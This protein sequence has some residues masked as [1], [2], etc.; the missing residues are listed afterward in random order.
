MYTASEV[1]SSSTQ[2]FARLDLPFCTI[3]SDVVSDGTRDFELMRIWIGIFGLLELEDVTRAKF[4]VLL[5]T[6][7]ACDRNKRGAAGVW[8]MQYVDVKRFEQTTSQM[9]IEFSECC[10]ECV[11]HV[12]IEIVFA[13]TRCLRRGVYGSL[14]SFLSL[15]LLPVSLL[16]TSLQLPNECSVSMLHLYTFRT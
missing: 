1:F 3:N 13:R 5:L 4:K 14:S 6:K 12:G 10:P 9:Y 8:T 7:L 15:S 16:L 11:T 2:L